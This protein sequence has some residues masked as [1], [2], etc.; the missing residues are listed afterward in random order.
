MLRAQAVGGCGRCGTAGGGLAARHCTAAWHGTAT[1]PLLALEPFCRCDAKDQSV[2]LFSLPPSW[3]PWV[4]AGEGAA[5]VEREVAAEQA[6]A[7]ARAEL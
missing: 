4:P 5:R 3:D 7:A 2:H 6:A 1:H